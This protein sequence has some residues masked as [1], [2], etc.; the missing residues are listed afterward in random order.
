MS[1]S[2]PRPSG[3]CLVLDS[4][5]S[6]GTTWRSKRSTT[7]VVSVAFIILAGSMLRRTTMPMPTSI[8][9]LLTR[10]S[11]SMSIPFPQSCCSSSNNLYYI[12]MHKESVYVYFFCGKKKKRCAT[13]K[14]S[15]LPSRF[16]ASDPVRNAVE[17][18][19]PKW[20]SLFFWIIANDTRTTSLS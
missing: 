3:G 4:M 20:I 16:S 19:E 7:S 14:P 5:T 9:R 12:I 6:T 13:K 11:M 15:A 1:P 10:L 18:E 8:P 2:T 17:E